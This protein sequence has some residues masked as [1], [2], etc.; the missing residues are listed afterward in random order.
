MDVVITAPNKLQRTHPPNRF[1]RSMAS[2]LENALSSPVKTK[3]RPAKQ[4]GSLGRGTSFEPGAEGPA[5]FATFAAQ[6][7]RTTY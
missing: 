3:D 6:L 1:A 2:S 5:A 4:F 7:Y